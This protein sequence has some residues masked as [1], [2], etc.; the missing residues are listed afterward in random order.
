MAKMPGEGMERQKLKTRRLD[1]SRA[2]FVIPLRI[3]SED[4]LRNARLVIEYLERYLDTNLLVIEYDTTRK[5]S[6]R[7]SSGNLRYIFYKT[8]D[9]NFWKTKVLNSAVQYVRTPCLVIQDADVIIEP[10]HLSDAYILVTR[11][12]ADIVFPFRNDVMWV[13]SE[14]VGAIDHLDA[15]EIS[16]WDYEVAS[17][18]KNDYLFVGLCVFV[19]LDSFVRIGK[20]NQ[21]IRS[22]GYEDVEFYERAKKLGLRIRRLT[23]MPYHLGHALSENSRPHDRYFVHNKRQYDLTINSSSEELA[24]IVENWKW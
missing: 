21:N 3:D 22:W 4:R 9:A 5:F 12:R 23:N 24:K 19:N 20:F 8:D 15:A 16:R 13:P 14:A 10:R 7:K 17:S 6:W 2:T 11:E 18:R 1:L